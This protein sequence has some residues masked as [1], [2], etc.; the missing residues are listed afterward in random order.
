MKL[1]S[2]GPTDWAWIVRASLDG[3][4]PIGVLT[5]F[6]LAYWLHF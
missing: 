1:K 5:M 2:E 4:K 6:C 3:V